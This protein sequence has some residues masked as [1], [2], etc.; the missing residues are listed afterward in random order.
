MPLHGRQDG[1]G[2]LITLNN[3]GSDPKQLLHWIFWGSHPHASCTPRSSS[4]GTNVG[5]RDRVWDSRPALSASDTY[6]AG[7]I[8]G[9]HI[10]AVVSGRHWK[11][12]G[13][14]HGWDRG[15]ALKRGLQSSQALAIH[16]IRAP[17]RTLT[18]TAASGNQPRP[19]ELP[20]RSVTLPT[21]GCTYSISP[22]CTS[23]LGQIFPSP[24]PVR[25]AVL[26]PPVLSGLATCRLPHSCTD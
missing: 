17:T 19:C 14:V 7:G 3:G 21:A 2:W 23:G 20:M 12:F 18:Q 8:F 26:H 16:D 24:T 22:A 9:G 10:L 11:S 5:T 1:A 25:P 13:S 15:D 4:S 6:P